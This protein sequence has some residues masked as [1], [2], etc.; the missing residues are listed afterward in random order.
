M[1][2]RKLLITDIIVPE[3]RVTARMDED[4]AKAFADSVAAIGVDEPVKV[5]QVE[6]K[7]YLSDGLHRLQ[8]AKKAGATTID[9]IVK[10]GTYE[11]V[12][13]NNLQSGH[14]R[15]KHP[16]SEMIK[17]IAYLWKE[18]GYDSIKIHEKTGLTQDYIEK[19]QKISRLTP[20]ILAGLDEGLIGVGQAFQFTRI[21]DPIQQESVYHTVKQYRFK[22]AE[23]E[24]FIDD[25][26]KMSVPQAVVGTAIPS[27]EPVLVRCEYCG[28]EGRPGE[29]ANPNTCAPC[30]M[31]MRQSIAMARVELESERAAQKKE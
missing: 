12:I 24:G 29:I 27:T 10:A 14:L 19:L 23:L 22:G 30:S 11:D 9:A 5:Y 2:L 26:I 21:A 16:V 15:G 8:E 7:F 3:V 28:A 17:S 18:K 4:T 20:L 13:C 31:A 25:V 6:D 1:K